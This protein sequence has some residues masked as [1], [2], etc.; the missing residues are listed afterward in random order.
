[1]KRTLI[2]AFAV[3]MMLGVPA[4]TAD[5]KLSGTFTGG[6][7]YANGTGEDQLGLTLVLDFNE[8]GLLSAHAPLALIG[9]IGIDAGWWVKYST[10]PLNVII[11]DNSVTGYKWVPIETTFGML[12]QGTTSNRLSRVWGDLTPGLNYAA[13]ASMDEITGFYTI[14]AQLGIGLP[15]GLALTSNFGW[16]HNADGYNMGLSTAL[17]GAIPV[18]GGNF[19]V[20]VGN[21][22]DLDLV[23]IPPMNFWN[24]D[25]LQAFAAYVGVLGIELGPITLSE[26]S[27]KM[28]MPGVYD[29]LFSSSSHFYTMDLQEVTSNILGIFEPVTIVF[30]N[31]LWFESFN[32]SGGNNANLDVAARIGALTLGLNIDSKL[33]WVSGLKHAE[34]L[35]L[36][37]DYAGGFGNIGGTLGYNSNWDGVGKYE[38]NPCHLRIGRSARN[39]VL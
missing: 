22:A 17:T 31:G 24:T 21:F 15:A 12:S 18:I 11:S 28:S 35:K 7:S 16:L 5:Y 38:V 9:G 19:K 37:A 8:A 30:K 34:Y 3:L 20:A 23:L 4:M 39:L 27:Y 10:I 36:R 26:I 29:G 33:N 25:D 13:E 6:Y 32:S 2:L 14:A 1:M